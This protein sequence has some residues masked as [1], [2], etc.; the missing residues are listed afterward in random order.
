MASEPVTKLVM[1]SE[2]SERGHLVDCHAPNGARNDDKISCLYYD[3]I[4][5]VSSDG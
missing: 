1:A 3:N 4:S 2:R 5:V